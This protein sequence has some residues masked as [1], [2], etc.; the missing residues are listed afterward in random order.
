MAAVIIYGPQGTGKTKHAPALAKHYG[1]RA[2]IDGMDLHAGMRDAKAPFPD[3][4]LVVTND[5]DLAKYHAEKH[6]AQVVQISDALKA[7]GI[8][9]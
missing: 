1:K 6:G 3:Y 4:A 9:A 8:K 7:A 2:V 5:D